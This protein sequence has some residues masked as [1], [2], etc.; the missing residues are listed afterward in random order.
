MASAL[1]AAGLANDAERRLFEAQRSQGLIAP[2]AGIA[3]QAWY[4]CVFHPE[5]EVLTGQIFGVI[6]PAVLLGRVTALRREGKLSMLSLI[7]ISEPTRPY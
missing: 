1:V 2:R 6:A 4:E 3:S 5:E 7:H